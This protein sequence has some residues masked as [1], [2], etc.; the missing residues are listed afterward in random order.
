MFS[1]AMGGLLAIFGLWLLGLCLHFDMAF[2]HLPFSK[3]L[4]LSQA[5]CH[6]VFETKPSCP[7]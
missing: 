5:T 4:H 3:F 6:I 7:I 1:L 2:F